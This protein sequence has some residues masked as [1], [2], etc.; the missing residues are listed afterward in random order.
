M[1]HTAPCSYNV[2][3]DGTPQFAK[4]IGFSGESKLLAY[5]FGSYP[6]GRWSDIDLCFLAP[7]SLTPQS[8]MEKLAGQLKDCGVTHIHMAHSIRC[9]RLK[10][11]LQFH[12]TPSIDYDIVF[13]IITHDDFSSLPSG[14]TQSLPSS[15]S[16]LLVPGDQ[17][18]RVAIA[19]PLFLHQVEEI[20]S[21][22]VSRKQFA[23]VVEMVVQL[24]VSR[25]QKGNAYHCMRTFHVVQLLVD[26]IKSHRT[27]LPPTLTCDSLFKEFVG[28][29]STLPEAK[30]RKLFGECVQG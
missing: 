4:V 8:C 20:I 3:R 7:A 23:A 9:P 24:L 11:N 27:E 18:S 2:T 13:A 12:N 29:A 26:F 17:E 10:T 22:V 25:R 30:W 14:H 6:L 5:P 1:E 28:Y 16:S 19:G 21:G 15:L